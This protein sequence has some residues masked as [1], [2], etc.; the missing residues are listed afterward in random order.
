MMNSYAICLQ[1][2]V[3]FGLVGGEYKCLVWLEY[4]K[5]HG[6]CM[7]TYIKTTRLGSHVVTFRGAPE[8]P[9]WVQQD[10]FCLNCM[11]ESRVEYRREGGIYD[12]PMWLNCS[13]VWAKDVCV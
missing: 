5:C 2:K 10:A 12:K 3:V 9:R 8:C 13:A 4:R 11:Y 7:E 6:Q 1:W